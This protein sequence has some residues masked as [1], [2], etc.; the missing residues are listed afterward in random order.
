MHSYT[1]AISHR[2]VCHTALALCVSTEHCSHWTWNSRMSC[3]LGLLYSPLSSGPSLMPSIWSIFQKRIVC[4]TPVIHTSYLNT[5]VGQW[6]SPLEVES[7]FE[8]R[9]AARSNLGRGDQK[10]EKQKGRTN[11]LTLNVFKLKVKSGK[12]K[13]ILAFH[14][15]CCTCKH[16]TWRTSPELRTRSTA[17][18][19]QEVSGT[20]SKWTT[21]IQ[22][23]RN[24]DVRPCTSLLTSLGTLSHRESCMSHLGFPESRSFVKKQ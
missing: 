13:D 20:N 2:S 1:W 14:Y 16:R 19:K 24:W 17:Q 6:P 3:W 8:L 15:K 10:E 4:T 9:L 7:I 12:G 18:G 22:K 5:S 23:G 11:P 21:K